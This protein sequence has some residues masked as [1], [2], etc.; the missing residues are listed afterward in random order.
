MQ[1]NKRHPARFW[2]LAFEDG[3]VYECVGRTPAAVL[4]HGNQEEARTQIM[5]IG[6]F[7]KC[8]PSDYVINF[9]HSI[10]SPCR[11]VDM[12]T[13]MAVAIQICS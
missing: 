11:K 9:R 1:K 10:R 3:S 2:G 8:R 13:G 12:S 5:L 4:R 6:D 7:I